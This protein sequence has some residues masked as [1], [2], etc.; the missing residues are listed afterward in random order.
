VRPWFAFLGL[1]AC[2]LLA[3]NALLTRFADEATVRII[4]PLIALALL[5]AAF[6]AWHRGA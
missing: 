3:V 4:L 1:A 2:A 5:G 6:V